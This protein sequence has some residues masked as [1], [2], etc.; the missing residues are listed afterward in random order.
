MSVTSEPEK[1]SRRISRIAIPLPMRVEV[2]VDQKNSW[3]EITRMQDASN[4]GTGFTLKRPVKRGRLVYMTMPLPRKLRN[5]DFAEPQYK[6]WGLVR[7]CLRNSNAN[8]EN[9]SLGVAFIGKEPPPGFLDN[10]SKLYDIS[11]QTENGLWELTNQPDVPDE[12]DLPKEL[13]RH[14]RF[15][16]PINLKL[17]TLDDNENAIA[18]E[19]TVT[20]N[21]SFSGASVF[22]SLPAEIGS[23]VRVT[24]DQYNVSIISIVRGKRTGADNIPRLH[25]E[26]VDRFFPLEGID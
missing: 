26:F 7:R 24:S 17:E 15:P 21:L 16:I 1:N 12:S 20:E 14:S 5:F 2:K 9:Y 19:D 3:D 4:F 10:P 11:H 22:T 23:F 6:V 18:V 8:A 25:I 13:R